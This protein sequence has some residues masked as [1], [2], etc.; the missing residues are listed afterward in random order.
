MSPRSRTGS[1]HVELKLKKDETVVWPG[2]GTAE[3]RLG[4][5]ESQAKAVLGAPDKRIRKHK[6]HYF[7]IYK[8]RGMDLD[9]GE[10]G[11]KLKV[12]FFFQKGVQEHDPA[13]IVTER[14]IRLGD[15]RSRVLEVYGKPDE[16]GE[17]FTLHTG[18]YFR[19]WF[20]Y[21]DGIQFRFNQKNTVDEI[22]ISRRKR[23]RGLRIGN[24][25]EATA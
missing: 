19:E 16:T 6:G 7:Y 4:W 24:R 2:Y 22:S 15:L 10:R 17:P 1:L 21:S 8:R 11:G 25:Q 3:I 13:R 12:I 23:N 9:F 5:G 14:G 20:Y 18:E